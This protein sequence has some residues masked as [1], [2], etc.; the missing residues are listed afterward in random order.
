MFGYVKV[1]KPEL[2]IREYEEYKAVYCTLCRVI[3]RDY[4]QISR[5]LLSYD[6]TFYVLLCLACQHGLYR[7]CFCRWGHVL[8]R[9]N[10]SAQTGV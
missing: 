9:M 10:L 8:I 2:K 3:G 5:T 7:N 6:A 4:G 1:C